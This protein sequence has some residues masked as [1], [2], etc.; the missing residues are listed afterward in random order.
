MRERRHAPAQMCKDNYAHIITRARQ[1]DLDHHET[2]AIHL[3]NLQ[4]KVGFR[5]ALDFIIN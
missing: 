3:A 5:A 2:Y 1:L 4:L